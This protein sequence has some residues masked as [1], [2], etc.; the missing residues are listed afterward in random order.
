MNVAKATMGIARNQSMSIYTSIATVNM[1]RWHI[2]M[3]LEDQEGEMEKK[4]TS[5]KGMYN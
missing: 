4:V 3:A 2:V 5:S 1:L